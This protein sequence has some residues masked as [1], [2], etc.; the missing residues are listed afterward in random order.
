MRPPTGRSS[1]CLAVNYNNPAL[2]PQRKIKSNMTNTLIE[3][4]SCQWINVCL[5]FRWKCSFLNEL[6]YHS[7]SNYRFAQHLFFLEHFIW[8]IDQRRM[9]HYIKVWQ[10]Y[11]TG[12]KK[13]IKHHSSYA[14][15]TLCGLI[16]SMHASHVFIVTESSSCLHLKSCQRHKNTP[17]LTLLLLHQQPLALCFTPL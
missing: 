14:G 15:T 17:T 11:S 2:P 6:E 10:I 3:I 7:W 4:I 5:H 9:L 1:F 8:H 12:K 13:C 16:P